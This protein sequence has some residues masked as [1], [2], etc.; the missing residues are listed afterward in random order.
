VRTL[1][2]FSKESAPRGVQPSMAS[3][4]TAESQ[5]GQPA[6]TC[7]PR[8]RLAKLPLP[9]PGAG[10]DERERLTFRAGFSTAAAGC[11]GL[12]AG[13]WTA[14]AAAGAG[15]C[16][17]DGRSGLDVEGRPWTQPMGVG[18]RRQQRRMERAGSEVGS[19][20]EVEGTELAVV[21]CGG[22]D[23]D[24]DAFSALSPCGCTMCGDTERRGKGM[25]KLKYGQTF[26][27]G[28]EGLPFYSFLL[29]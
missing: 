2:I 12:T 27:H 18:H 29:Q 17:G 3:P 14:T 22:F 15:S 7:S 10:R 23:S 1:S 16:W 13:S 25:G 24:T 26:W 6:A 5:A 11:S 4:A 19:A 28:M 20:S 21:R 9:G 8:A